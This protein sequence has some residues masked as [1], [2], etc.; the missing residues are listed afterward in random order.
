MRGQTYV[1][2]TIIFIIIIAVFAVLN[3][4]S[5]EVTYFF[6]KVK[7]PLI[8][9]ILF[10]VLLGVIVTTSVSMFKYIQ[11]RRKNRELKQ[12][13]VQLESILSKHD[14]LEKEDKNKSS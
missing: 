14:L 7:S 3:I 6:W 5:V 4:E 8:L 9:I 12:E 10:S 1:I 2:L 13:I 11:L